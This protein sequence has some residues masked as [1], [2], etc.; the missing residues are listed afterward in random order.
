MADIPPPHRN[1]FWLP[2]IAV[3]LVAAAIT[4]GILAAQ[5]WHGLQGMVSAG[6]RQATAL[7]GQLTALRQ[8]NQINREGLVASNRAYVVFRGLNLTGSIN[9]DDPSLSRFQINPVW[10]NVG[11]TP[12]RNMTIYTNPA[13]PILHPILDMAMPK[14]PDISAGMLAPHATGMGS[15]THVTGA[16][17]LAIRDGKLRMYMWGW[18]R[19]HDVFDA[20]AERLSRFCII[21][22]SFQ[23]DPNVPGEAAVSGPPCGPY[24][25]NYECTD[26][27]C[28][29]QR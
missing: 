10:E 11:N 29:P 21:V 25:D 26:A 18:A 1:Q 16:D 14:T 23:G 15:S 12:T 7:E 5:Q 22:S 4:Q 6:R 3:I 8:A 28:G 13:K 19:Y 27:E 24:G 20:T 9:N 2:A 17:L